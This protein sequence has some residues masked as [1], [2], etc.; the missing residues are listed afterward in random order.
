MTH[1]DETPKGKANWKNPTADRPREYPCRR[2]AGLGS[3]NITGSVLRVPYRNDDAWLR[4]RPR[5]LILC[6]RDAFCQKSPATGRKSPAFELS[7]TAAQAGWRGRFGRSE[8]PPHPAQRPPHN[9]GI[10]WGFMIFQT[11]PLKAVSVDVT[12]PSYQAAARVGRRKEKGLFDRST[13]GR[14][15]N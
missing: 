1:N 2:A 4:P 6:R 12:Y 11:G 15:Q 14:S 10:Y 13:I 9:G 3:Q 8:H 5:K 7:S